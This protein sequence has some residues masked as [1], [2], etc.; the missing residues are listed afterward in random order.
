MS[1]PTTPSLVTPECSPSA[2]YELGDG[3]AREESL[4]DAL[5]GQLF[6]GADP[7]LAL[8]GVLGLQPQRQL[9]ADVR[10]S[11]YGVYREAT[12]TVAT[13]QD[14]KTEPGYPQLE[15]AAYADVDETDDEHPDF[16][17]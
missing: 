11:S 17:G 12:D 9:C 8:D 2:T 4:Y 6:E 3:N 10:T 16:P 14:Q 15:Q 5:H 7:W 1:F 13:G